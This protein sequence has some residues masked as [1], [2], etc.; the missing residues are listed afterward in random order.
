MTV[1]EKGA[2]LVLAPQT[3]TKKTHN[4]GQQADKHRIFR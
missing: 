3:H 2:E 1:G 4:A